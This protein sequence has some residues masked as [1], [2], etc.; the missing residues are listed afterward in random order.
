MWMEKN[1]IDYYLNAHTFLQIYV[2]SN[3][4][5]FYIHLIYRLMISSP[6]WKIPQNIV[7]AYALSRY[8]NASVSGRISS[9]CEWTCIEI[10]REFYTSESNL[11]TYTGA[12]L[13]TTACNFIHF[14]SIHETARA[15]FHSHSM[16]IF[17]FILMCCF[18][19][20]PKDI[21]LDLFLCFLKFQFW[22]F[23]FIF[24]MLQ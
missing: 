14:I 15:T 7:Y 13:I 18:Y 11:K 3:I 4:L 10:F 23:H 6:L 17:I 21:D 9:H 19:I 1:D 8:S 5:H 16:V 20:Y 22:L 24:K 2:T 12:T